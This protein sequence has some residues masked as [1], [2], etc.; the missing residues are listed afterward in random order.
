MHCGNYLGLQL[1]LF[2][3]SKQ[4][5]AIRTLATR[6]IGPKQQPRALLKIEGFISEKAGTM[7]LII[8]GGHHLE[9]IKAFNKEVAEVCD[10]SNE[11]VG[12]DLP[13]KSHAKRQIE[14]EVVVTELRFNDIN[15]FEQFLGAPP[16]KEFFV[17]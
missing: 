12:V 15:E 3:E 5:N 6:Y 17:A 7:L 16:L 1:I 14:T 2:T 9:G 10:R 13:S 8:D 11:L 4:T